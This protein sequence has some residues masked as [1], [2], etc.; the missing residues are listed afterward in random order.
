[1]S[2][3]IRKEGEERRPVTLTRLAEM[4]EAGE[5]IAMITA[6]DFPSAQVIEEGFRPALT[7][8][9]RRHPVTEGLEREE[10]EGGWGRWFRLI[11]VEQVAGQVL[12]SGP[13][14]L[15]LLVLNRV[16]LGR[17]AVL[18][19]DHAWLWGRGFEGGGPQLELLRRLAHWMLKEPELE[20]ETLTA[21]VEG[22][23]MTITRRT[24][25][26]EEPGPV[27]VTGPDGTAVELPMPLAAPGRYET[28]WQAPAASQLPHCCTCRARPVSTLRCS[29]PKVVRW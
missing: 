6:Y 22:E 2:S 23:A 29:V 25:A 8:L 14:D 5:P 1:M 27:T 28:V 4:H 24:L 17:V 18:A 15:P 13:R 20:E 12:M 11:E 9:G 10:P 19:S 16:D 3:G 21:E 7:D 26:E